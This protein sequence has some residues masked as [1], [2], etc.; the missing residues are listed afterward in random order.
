MKTLGHFF[1]IESQI[2]TPSDAAKL[3]PVLNQSSFVGALYSPADGGLDPSMFCSA[4]IKG[5]T[6][7]G[8][9]ILEH[10]PVT[11]IIIDSSTGV[12][13]IKGVETPQ[14]VIKTSCIV[15]AAGIWAR[16]IAQMVGLDV[17]LT[18]MKHAYVVTEPI[19]G[20]KGTPNIRDHDGSIYYRVQGESLFLG[21]YE[22]NPEIVKEVRSDQRC[23]LQ[24]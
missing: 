5:A 3:S 20:V 12:R 16:N 9:E 7:R 8:A 23:L 6:S 17:P 21:G 11:N 22:K 4:L 13:K 24:N 19:R 15:N 14:G 10:C 1:G 18:I 2:L